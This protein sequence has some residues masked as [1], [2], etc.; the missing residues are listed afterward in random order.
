MDKYTTQSKITADKDGIEAKKTII[1]DDAYAV[2]DLISDLIIKIEH[3]RL[4]LMK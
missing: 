3:A 4:S 1:S 2:A